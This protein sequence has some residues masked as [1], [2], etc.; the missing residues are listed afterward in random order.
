[1]GKSNSV[2]YQLERFSINL[3][4]RLPTF[5]QLDEVGNLPPLPPLR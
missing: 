4:G 1:M 2:F 5:E 3:I